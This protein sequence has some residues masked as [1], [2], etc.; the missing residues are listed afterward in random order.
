M[1]N[2]PL[3]LIIILGVS[4]IV[5]LNDQSLLSKVGYF[6]CFNCTK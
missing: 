3:G 2:Q 1:L 6:H 5:V 4:V